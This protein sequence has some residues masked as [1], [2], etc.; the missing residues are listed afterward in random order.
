MPTHGEPAWTIDGFA[1]LREVG[2][3]GSAVV[4]SAQQLGLGRPVAIKVL[5]ASLTDDGA[6]RRFEREAAVLG[7]L[8]EVPG[9]V[10]VHAVAV[11]SDG[12][13]CIVMR[14]MAESMA[15]RVRRDGPLGASEVRDVGVIA[16]RALA[17]AHRHGIV[18]RDVKPGNLLV[19]N[20]GVVAVSDFDIAASAAAMSTQTNDA[21]S[22]PHAPPERLRGAPDVD[23]AGD[24]WSLGSTLYALLT[25]RPPFGDA[26]SD[27]GMAGLID[28][29]LT[30][31]VPPIERP[32][33]PAE[34]EGVIA[35]ALEKDPADRWENMTAFAEALAA[36]SVGA[37]GD[38]PRPEPHSGVV[39]SGSSSASATPASSPPWSSLVASAVVLAV[40][41]AAVAV[42][43]FIALR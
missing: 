3:G 5:R 37:A 25:D 28:R 19:D 10:P 39:S 29:V 20:D 15:E 38:V 8:A 14:L 16:A 42:A 21:L 2:K 11:T 30:E 17:E 18:H 43:L 9:I 34:L 33:V 1:D 41:A 27:G 12:R 36:T 26:T 13:G 24:I 32:E 23:V 40:A 22:P 6:R 7:A 4:Y 35:R 31:P